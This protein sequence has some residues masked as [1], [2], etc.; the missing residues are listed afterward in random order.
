MFK[1]NHQVAEKFS[2]SEE[3]QNDLI[4]KGVAEQKTASV[5]NNG[6]TI[7]L[8]Q[9]LQDKDYLYIAVE[10][11][12]P[13]DIMLSGTNLFEGSG[14]DLAGGYSAV[15]GFYCTSKRRETNEYKEV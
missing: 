12:A 4:L 14:V 8:V 13:E 10:V 6:L 7:S 5:T 15:T 2:A 9:T 1:W 11:T 3:Y